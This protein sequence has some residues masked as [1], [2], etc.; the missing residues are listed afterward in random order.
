MFKK[1]F[2]NIWCHFGEDKIISFFLQ[3]DI[4]DYYFLYP[5]TWYSRLLF[6][7]SYYLLF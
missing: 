3:L 1:A 4:L 5:I 2:A 6:P 7:L